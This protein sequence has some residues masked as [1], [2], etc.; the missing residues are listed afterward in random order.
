MRR[1]GDNV[2]DRYL[3]AGL[4]YPGGSAANVAVHSRRLGATARLPRRPR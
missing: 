1:G 2:V 3:H 4:M